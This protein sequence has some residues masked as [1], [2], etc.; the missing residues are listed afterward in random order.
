MVDI[1]NF[2]SFGTP[3]LKQNYQQAMQWLQKSA[4]LYNH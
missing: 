4:A 3:P 1:A 2:Y